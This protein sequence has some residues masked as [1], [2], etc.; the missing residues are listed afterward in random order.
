MRAKLERDFDGGAIVI[1]TRRRWYRAGAW[2]GIAPGHHK[3]L[4][5]TPG[6]VHGWNLRV[7]SL[8]KCL[9]LL[10]HTRPRDDRYDR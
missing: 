4:W 3:G 6:R 2:F 7:G 5:H 9:T 8:H 10:G 1:T